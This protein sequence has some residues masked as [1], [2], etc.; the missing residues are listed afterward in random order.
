MKSKLIRYAVGLIVTVL[1]LW[2]SFRNLDWAEL[3]ESFTS[4]HL[5]WVILAVIN[6]LFTVYAMGWRW[7]LLL[8]S[9]KDIP[10]GYMFQLNVIAQYI[11]IVLPGRFGEIAKAWLPAKRY[12]LSGS[13]VLGTV[14][15]EKMFDFFAGVILWVS[16]SAFVAFH[17]EIKGYTM[18]ALVICIILIILLVL[19]L[20]KREM[21]RKLLYFFSSLLPEGKFKQRVVNF[22]EKGME[23]FSQLKD[24]KTSLGLALYTVLIIL[25][26]TL[27]NFLLFLAFGFKLSF[28]E[29]MVLLLIIQVGNAPPSVPGKVGIFEYMVILGLWL[30]S[31]EK[32]DAMGY[33]L[34]LHVVSYLPK[35]ILGFLFMANLN[36]SIKKAESEMTQF[37]EKGNNPP[38]EASIK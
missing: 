19:V 36:I 22:L 24:S 29:A 23:A 13:Y 10:L 20:W 25:L 32:A 30:F 15:I 28:F 17:G 1:A 26:S 6:V 37:Q 4:V 16:I 11:N 18:M 5:F 31:I 8:K 38:G 9:K 33:A 14:V 3:G 7:R 12:E 35:I 21:V 27:T 2:L 34:M